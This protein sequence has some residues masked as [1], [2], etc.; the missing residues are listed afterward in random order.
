MSA[1]DGVSNNIYGL[2]LSELDEINRS[3]HEF[4]L[5]NNGD[6]TRDEL[7]QCLK[8]ANVVATDTIVESVLKQMDWDHDDKISYGEYL[9]FMATIYR[10]EHSDLK[11]QSDS[12]SSNVGSVT[13]SY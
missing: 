7:K 12:T 13:K 4:D 8:Q 1:L 11:R 5:N 2:K 6:I 10:N 9:K 3:F